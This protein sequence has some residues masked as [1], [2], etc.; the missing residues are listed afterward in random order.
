[1]HD[2][3][4]SGRAAVDFF[5]TGADGDD[6][7]VGGPVGDDRRFADDDAGGAADELRVRAQQVFLGPG[8]E[9][10][11]RFQRHRQAI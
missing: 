4:E 3:N 2:A 5:G 1:M 9:Q 7:V 11:F 6:R 8:A 10:G